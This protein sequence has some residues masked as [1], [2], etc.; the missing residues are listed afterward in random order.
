[1]APT[2]EVTSIAVFYRGEE[3]VGGGWIVKN[4]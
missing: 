4:G 2:R 3:V 1:L